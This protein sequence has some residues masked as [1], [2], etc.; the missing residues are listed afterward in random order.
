[1]LTKRESNFLHKKLIEGMKRVVSDTDLKSVS[2]I[3]NL[4]KDN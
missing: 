3:L 2:A 1:M 4:C